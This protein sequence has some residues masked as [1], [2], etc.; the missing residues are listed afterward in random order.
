MVTRPWVAREA[1]EIAATLFPDYYPRAKKSLE[2]AERLYI[3][4]LKT[5]KMDEG[6]LKAALLP[7]LI[8]Y[9]EQVSLMKTLGM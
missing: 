8:R 2:E 7:N 1:V 4:Y 9:I 3:T 6:I 5:G